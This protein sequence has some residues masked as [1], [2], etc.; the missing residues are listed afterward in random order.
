MNSKIIINL[1]CIA[2]LLA[3]ILPSSGS[4]QIPD[5]AYFRVEASNLRP[6]V[7]EPVTI[8]V[9]LELNKTYDHCIIA[10]GNN[11]NIIFEPS[12][13]IWKGMIVIKAGEK[14][15]KK[16]NVKFPKAEVTDV[17]IHIFQTLPSTGFYRTLK[18]YVGGAFEENEK[19]ER[20]K[21]QIYTMKA[22]LQRIKAAP[23]W[24][25]YKY[26]DPEKMDSILASVK[27]YKKLDPETEGKNEKLLSE[28][29]KE[30]T[31]LYKE[32]IDKLRNVTRIKRE[33]KN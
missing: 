14:F 16:Y 8:T 19:V 7:N 27:T 18:F 6:A 22:Q 21:G 30:Y 32:N 10:L 31:K 33:D 11:D 24:E 2:I 20:L 4:A 13:T 29:R 28:L 26:D 23:E 15:Q 1:I 12:D 17:T 25:Y 9:D 5:T 3:F